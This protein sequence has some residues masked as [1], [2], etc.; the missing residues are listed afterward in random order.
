MLVEA[1]IQKI[2]QLL[3]AVTKN[4]VSFLMRLIK[5]ISLFC[6]FFIIF[7]CSGTR[8]KDLGLIYRQI[9]KKPNNK[10]FISN[11]EGWESLISSFQILLN[12]QSIGTL[13]RDEILIGEGKDGKN[14]LKVVSKMYQFMGDSNTY[15]FENKNKENRFFNVTIK[16]KSCMV[17]QC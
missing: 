13:G 12:G 17:F 9:D 6:F 7:S 16:K 11:V 8:T 5:L 3:Y 1:Q 14:T 10:V 4:G 2:T 15:I